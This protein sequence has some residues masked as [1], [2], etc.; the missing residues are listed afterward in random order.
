M[1]RIRSIEYSFVY[2]DVD[3]ASDRSCLIRD[4]VLFID[5]VIL[6]RASDCYWRILAERARLKL[7]EQLQENRQ[8]CAHVIDINF[9][10]LC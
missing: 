7:D 4:L 3:I 1:N 8:V 5:I 6:D 10:S 9:L 2:C